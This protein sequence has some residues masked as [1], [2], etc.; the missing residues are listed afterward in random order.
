MNRKRARIQI[1]GTV[2]GVGFRP[3]IYRLAGSLRINGWVANSS[4]GVLIE[5]E[6]AA[7]DLT[8]FLARIVAEKPRLAMIQNL[9][10]TFLPPANYSRF[11]IRGSN[12][13]GATTALILPDI[14]TCPECLREIFDPKDRRYRY[15]FT[16]CTHCGP[17]FS[18]IH[19]L[20]Y[21]RLNS[22]MKS[23][24]M[25]AE[26]EAEYHNPCDRRF[27]AQPNACAK[28]GPR[29]EIWD[30]DGSCLAIEDGALLRAAVAVISG[31]IVA[32]KG[33]GGFQLVVDARNEEAV[34]RLRT[35]KRRPEKPFAVMFPSV[36]AIERCCQMD[37]VGHELLISPAAP[38]VL[39]KRIAGRTESSVGIAPS[40][41]PG[42]PWLG[43]M[44]PYSP[45]HHL[46]LQL[47]EFPVVATSGN[48]GDEPICIDEREALDRLRNI[49]DVFLVHNRPIVRHVDDS[50][51]RVIS[52]RA[53]VLRRAR[54]FAPLPV[55]FKFEISDLKSETTLAVGA[56][57]K[58]TVALSL[59]NRI[60]VS[61]HIGNLE[62]AQAFSAFQ[63]SAAD[64]P[65][66]YRAAPQ[67]VVHDLHPEY[68][69]TKFAQQMPVR[70]IAVQHHY[71]HVL[72]CMVD[73]ELTGSALGVSWDGTGLGLD[74]TIWGGEFLR[75]ND[76]SFERV[77]HFRQF[78]LPGGDA[79][80]AD[81]RRSAL[82]LLYEILGPDLFRRNDLIPLRHVS[83]TEL[84][85]FERMLDAQIN[86]PMTSSAGRFFDAV[87][88][89][90]GVRQRTTFEGQAA[91]DLEFVATPGLREFYGVALRREAPM[92]F[93][94]ESMIL[95]MLS[96]LGRNLP[97]GV[98]AAKV[99]NT[100]VELIV[101]VAQAAAEANVVLSGGCFQNQYLAER[102]ISRLR[103]EGFNPYWHCRIP[104]NDGGIALGQIAAAIRMR[105]GEGA[106]GSEPNGQ[107]EA[108]D[109]ELTQV[110]R[111]FWDH[112]FA[113]RT[114]K[115]KRCV[116]R[117]LERCLRFSETNKA[118]A[119]GKR[120]LA[121]SSNRCALNTRR[122]C[123]AAIMYSFMWDSL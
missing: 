56:H 63:R 2:Q 88:S 73:N 25:C 1:A 112:D 65:R 55:D 97:V 77:A 51:A 28:C 41:A 20:P 40:V 33:I 29:L 49:A 123:N 23:F 80:I 92:L 4:Q 24:I 9:Q 109:A 61:Q 36:S 53:M 96:D 26:C 59:G 15:P 54:G 89:I 39:F 58:N 86:A 34:R 106:V 62:T 82:G 35:R 85:T 60:F 45:L 114:E 21:D 50:V 110:L 13:N 108:K 120:I 107:S 94:W 64:L 115:G 46:L 99:H 68:L 90:L 121:A 102:A 98:I 17:R 22:S 52:G 69:S 43:V 42:N 122:T 118:C 5:A 74:G 113:L 38:I 116:W 44:V 31:E 19:A 117:F 81:P 8:E 91:M 103:E 32:V 37:T 95:A 47:L 67:V 111:W 14:A 71:A 104:P 70:S 12:A 57:L 75:I 76:S 48:L 119:W 105:A 78:R 3:F 11:E 101:S 72:S 16:N 87:A 93:D 18:I 84:R 83:R 27:H 10:Q 79:A 30:S 100:M 66:L 7:S 6:G